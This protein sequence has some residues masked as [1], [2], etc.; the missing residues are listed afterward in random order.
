M[1][2]IPVYS[3]EVWLHTS[4][5]VYWNK[6]FFLHLIQV[7]TK[8]VQ[9]LMIVI[10]VCVYVT[11]TV[12][13]QQS[14]THCTQDHQPEHSCYPMREI[15]SINNGSY[16][17]RT[18]TTSLYD[19]KNNEYTITFHQNYLKIHEQSIPRVT[20]LKLCHK[21]ALQLTVNDVECGLNCTTEI[22]HFMANSV[23]IRCVSDEFFT[24][25]QTII[26]FRPNSTL[27]SCQNSS[28][29]LVLIG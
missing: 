9:V 6:H 16:A 7:C 26:A 28:M 2:C 21:E 18:V 23:S 17:P 13:A 4:R 10:I 3:D 22:Y 24:G 20:M 1:E 5:I 19:M 25:N 11:N 27:L 12:L 29:N 8:M 15:I 14:P